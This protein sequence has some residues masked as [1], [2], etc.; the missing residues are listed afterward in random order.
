MLLI[1][2]MECLWLQITDE[3]SGSTLFIEKGFSDPKLLNTYSNHVRLH[4]T[5]DESGTET[6]F[7]IAYGSKSSTTIHVHMG[8]HR[9]G[10][11]GTCPPP[12]SLEFYIYDSN[13]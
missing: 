9:T 3:N 12:T 6:G 5:S 4:F 1:R 2:E 10:Q 7:R 8:D 11:G 13:S